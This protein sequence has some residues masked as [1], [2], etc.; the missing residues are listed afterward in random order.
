MESHIVL[1][2]LPGLMCG[3][4]ERRIIPRLVGDADRLRLEYVL[5]ATVVGDA[6]AHDGLVQD[7]VPLMSILFDATA[8]AGSP[9]VVVAIFEFIRWRKRSALVIRFSFA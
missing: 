6:V 9:V 5:A 2:I 3:V 7:A 1:R 8:L 4:R